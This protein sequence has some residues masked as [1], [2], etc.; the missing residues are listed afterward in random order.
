MCDKLFA[1][2]VCQEGDGEVV[3]C[4]TSDDYYYYA[5]YMIFK[6]SWV[7]LMVQ[8]VVFSSHSS[9]VTETN[10]FVIVCTYIS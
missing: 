4:H 5:V 6:A 1:S 10:S 3:E 2:L 7:S 8:K 9:I